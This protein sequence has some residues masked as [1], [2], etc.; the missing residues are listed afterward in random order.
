MARIVKEARLELVWSDGH[1]VDMGTL[2]IDAKEKEVRLIGMRRIRQRIGWELVRTG[3]R[4]M[5]P[6]KKWRTDF[7]S[8]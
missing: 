1:R 8:Q 7:D 2:T 6:W 4:I 5:M 3:V